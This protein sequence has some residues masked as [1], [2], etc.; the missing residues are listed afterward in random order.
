MDVKKKIL[1]RKLR[2]LLNAI[3]KDEQSFYFTGSDLDEALG[4]EAENADWNNIKIESSYLK[5]SQS[6]FGITTWNSFNTSKILQDIMKKLETYFYDTLEEH[7]IMYYDAESR[8]GLNAGF[9]DAFLIPE[10]NLSDVITRPGRSPYPAFRFVVSNVI[11]GFPGGGY[12]IVTNARGIYLIVVIISSESPLIIQFQE[13]LEYAQRLKEKFLVENSSNND[14]VC[15]LGAIISNE[16]T[17]TFVSEKDEIIA[18]AANESYLANKQAI[19]E[20]Y[21]V[22]SQPVYDDQARLRLEDQAYYYD[23]YDDSDDPDYVKYT[24]MMGAIHCNE[25]S[26]DFSMCSIEHIDIRK[27]KLFFNAICKGQT[28]FP[29]IHDNTSDTSDF[30]HLSSNFINISDGFAWNTADVHKILENVIKLLLV[31]YRYKADYAKHDHELRRHL[32]LLVDL[33]DENQDVELQSKFLYDIKKWL[34]GFELLN[35]IN[36]KHKKEEAANQSRNLVMTNGYGVFALIV[37]KSIM[38]NAQRSSEKANLLVKARQIKQQYVDTYKDLASFIVIIGAIFTNEKGGT[39]EFINDTDE[40]IA[41]AVNWWKPVKRAPYIDEHSRRYFHPLFG[42]KDSSVEYIP[43][44]GKARGYYFVKQPNSLIIEFEQCPQSW[45]KTSYETL[46]AHVPPAFLP[47]K[48][49]PPPPEGNIW[50]GTKFVAT[51]ISKFFGN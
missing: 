24:P 17:I 10:V 37:T 9:N 14:V 7:K 43:L 25:R 26:H 33:T 41:S 45:D 40:Q 29:M 15:V 13:E 46:M 23:D 50:N 42:M 35:Q 1:L 21:S 5:E 18:R 44:Y 22:V 48:K 3:Q 12:Q 19:D 39:L 38:K 20:I 16:I 2:L 30:G 32:P 47:Q 28:S 11:Q 31:R 27:S 34:P 6:G 49:D 51:Y 8:P 36:W 4:K